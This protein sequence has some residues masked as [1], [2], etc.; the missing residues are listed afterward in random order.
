[1]DSYLRTRFNMLHEYV[2]TEAE[3]GFMW[4]KPAVCDQQQH[5]NEHSV[6][7]QQEGVRPAGRDDAGG[8]G[9]EEEEEEDRQEDPPAVHQRRRIRYLPLSIR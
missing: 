1:M 8:R 3:G 9:G 6:R 4:S 2:I 7:H 5:N